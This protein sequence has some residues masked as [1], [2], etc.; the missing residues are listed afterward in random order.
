[1][2]GVYACGHGRP[3]DVPSCPGRDP[4]VPRGLPVPGRAGT[5]HLRRQGQEPAPAPVQLLPGP[6]RPAPAHPEDG[7]HRMRGGV[8]GGVHRGGVPGPGV[9]LDQGVQPPFQRHVQGRQVLPLPGGDDGGDLPPRAGSPRGPQ[10]GNPLL[11]PLRPGLVHPRDRRAAAEGLPS[12]FL[13]SRRLPPRPG[14]GAS[15]LVGVHRQVLGP[16]C[17][18]HQPAG[19][20]G[21]GR[22]LLRLHGR[23]HRP[24]P[25]PGRG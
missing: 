11:R 7:H 2:M 10:T 8:D 25:A 16:L 17:G 13:L 15:L 18:P 24:L 3:L 20:S 22:G 1:M 21:A 12:A 6:R 4:N 23:S 19:P 9:L 5:G 14:F